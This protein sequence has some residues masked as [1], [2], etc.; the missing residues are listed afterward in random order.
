MEQKVN[1]SK[2]FKLGEINHGLEIRLKFCDYFYRHRMR[3]K[4]QVDEFGEKLTSDI[5]EI[6][7]IISKDGIIKPDKE[8]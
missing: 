4:I 2:K 3:Q 5:C 7:H 1:I 8:E 6:A